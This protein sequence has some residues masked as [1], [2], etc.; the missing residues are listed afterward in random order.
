MAPVDAR[1]GG[2]LSSES[3]GFAPQNRFSRERSPRR[4][5]SA[6]TVSVSPFRSVRIVRP[7]M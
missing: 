5:K 1:K 4:S 2:Q 6:A 7:S 3:R